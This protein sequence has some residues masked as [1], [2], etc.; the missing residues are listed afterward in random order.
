MF[1]RNLN[2]EKIISGKNNPESQSSFSKNKYILVISAFS[3]FLSGFSISVISV[4]LITMA[5]DFVISA[6]VQN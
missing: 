4:V 6:A 1:N 2:L 3:Y 5:R